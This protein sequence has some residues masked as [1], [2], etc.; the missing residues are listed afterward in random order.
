MERKTKVLLAVLTLF[1]V[2]FI[3]FSATYASSGKNWWEGAGNWYEGG[4]L[5]D[6]TEAQGFLNVL[7]DMANVVGTSVIVLVTV[8]LGIKYMYGSVESK[9][10]VKQS[11]TTLLVACIFFFGWQS[12]SNLLMPGNQLIFIQNS[13][14]SYTHLVGRI[15]STFMYIAN[16]AAILGVI[17]VGVRYIFSGASGKA[18]LKAKSGQFV[19]G[20]ILTFATINVLTYISKIINE[21]II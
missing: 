5:D 14:T 1:M 15:F 18:D 13:D 12:I 9:A 6:V 8:F 19:I 20:V 2:L 7:T 11:L 16:I 3:S 10:D 4:K 17:Y 21:V